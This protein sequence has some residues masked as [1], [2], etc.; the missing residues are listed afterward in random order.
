[1]QTTKQHQDTIARLNTLQAYFEG[2]LSNDPQTLNLI[3]R[4]INSI[5]S[6]ISKYLDT[7]QATDSQ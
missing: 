7:L 5:K 3:K 2:L 4:N 6:I 1:M